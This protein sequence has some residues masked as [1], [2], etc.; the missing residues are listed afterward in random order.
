MRFLAYAK[1]LHTPG[2]KHNVDAVLQ[3]SVSA[4]KPLYEKLKGEMTMCEA[5]EWL[6]QDEI[7]EKVAEGM[8][9][10]EARGIAEAEE[11]GEARGRQNTLINLIRALM[12]SSRIDVNEA[13]ARLQIPTG[14]RE[15]L[16]Q[17]I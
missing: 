15:A 10:A 3:V 16:K 6:F 1:M 12:D 8:A 7:A 4:N 11:R 17:M 13:M 14:E 9:Q 5:L 2:D